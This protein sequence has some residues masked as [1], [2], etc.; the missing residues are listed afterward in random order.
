[1]ESNNAQSKTNGTDGSNRQ[2]VVVGFDSADVDLIL[3]WAKE[4]IL[5]TFGKLLN[6]AAWGRIENTVT[7]VAGSV[8]PTFHTGVWPGKHGHY[9]GVKHFD[10]ETYEDG[11]YFANRSEVP[12]EQIWEIL[13]GK[14]HRVAVL[15]APFAFLPESLN[16]LMLDGW[17]THERNLAGR[18]RFDFQTI[19]VA[20]R[21]DVLSQYGE[22]PLGIQ[23]APC[24]VLK[25]RN[26]KELI[27][28][29]DAL[30]RG[31]ETK[32][33]MAVDFLKQEPWAYF[34]ANFFAAH[35]I[36][37]QCWHYHDPEH[38]RYDADATRAVGDP[39]RDV[40]MALD[41]GLGQVL[42]AIDSDARVIV[43][44][45]HGMGPNYTA[46]GGLLDK[47][48]LRLENIESPERAERAIT[49]ARKVWRSAPTPLR[50]LLVPVRARRFEA[51]IQKRIQPAKSER[52]FF[53]QHIDGATGGIRINLEGRESHGKV[54]PGD[55]Y[56]A[57][58]ESLIH[59][60]SEVVNADTG[61]PLVAKVFRSSQIYDGPFVDRMPDLF[62]EWNR[63][64]PISRVS[65]PKIGT[66]IDSNPSMRSGDHR[67]EGW[68]AALLPGIPAG[69]VKGRV[70]VVD[71][72][73]TIAAL[74][75]VEDGDFDG[76]PIAALSPQT[77]LLRL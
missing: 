70:A 30:I 77:P 43:Y 17:G 10:P 50:R 18:D 66:V 6:K 24:D 60:L 48:L 46:T 52:K 26:L 58:C 27:W 28:F 74:L 5:P 3:G 31:V 51:R 59:D 19:P 23:E 13:S 32:A 63:E 38:P 69:E 25:P 61:S 22:D 55:E 7:N 64:R 15:D 67:P 68:F 62:I 40:Y 41:R 2:V 9:E 11:V 73:P 4:G 16:G 44:C 14:G 54:K 21:S 47:I 72:A 20:L 39:V 1:L 29:R 35:C 71:F 36:G 56:E 49:I 8:W 45:S 53:E 12:R 33:R 75:G 37:H 57:L 65:S 42:D 34:E 76:T